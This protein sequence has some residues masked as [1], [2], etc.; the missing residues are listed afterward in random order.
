MANRPRIVDENKD[1]PTMDDLRV[2]LREI[3]NLWHAGDN[4]IIAEARTAL[5]E[6]LHR[7]AKRLQQRIK[8]PDH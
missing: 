7:S 3:K 1:P 4:K 2:I 8:P 6:I 5:L